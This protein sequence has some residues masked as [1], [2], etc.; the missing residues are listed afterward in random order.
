MSI[1]P[2]CTHSSV[3]L[4]F[5]Y[6]ALH[7]SNGYL[8][9]LCFDLSMSPDWNE[10]VQDGFELNSRT[11]SWLTFSVFFKAFQAAVNVYPSVEM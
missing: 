10:A 7:N 3:L 11:K 4:L 2:M 1:S 6:E 8:V 5:K 9:E